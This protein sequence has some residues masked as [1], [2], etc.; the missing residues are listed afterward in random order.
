MKQSVFRNKETGEIISTPN[1]DNYAD[2]EHEFLGE[3]EEPAEDERWCDDSNC[4]KPCA[5]LKEARGKRL[6]ADRIRI[7]ELEERVAS[8]EKLV[9]GLSASGT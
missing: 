3:A 5:I 9:E 7:A 4:F 1:P 6:K 2:D 8:L